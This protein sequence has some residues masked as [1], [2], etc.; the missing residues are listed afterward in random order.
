MTLLIDAQLPIALARYLL[1]LGWATVHVADLGMIASNDRAIWN[2]A[3]SHRFVIVTKDRDFLALAQQ[4]RTIPP[5]VLLVRMGNC[6]RQALFAAFTR[7]WSRLHKELSSGAQVV[8]L[9]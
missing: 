8:E 6:R 7:E 1:A 5:Q 2:Y 4:Q 3:R 9:T